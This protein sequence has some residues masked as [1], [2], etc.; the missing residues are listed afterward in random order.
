MVFV[1]LFFILS[2]HLLSMSRRPE[3]SVTKHGGRLKVK[4]THEYYYYYL[5]ASTTAIAGIF[6]LILIPSQTLREGI[7]FLISGII[8]LFWVIPM[9]RRWGKQWYYTG[10]VGT[11]AL[12]ILYETTRVSNPITSD[13][14]PIDTAGIAVQVFQVAFVI[15]TGIIVKTISKRKELS[16]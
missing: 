9:I 13:G 2:S 3:E 4:G 16:G 12:I 8:Q 14:E 5:A 6:H 7:F 1:S 15:I 11:L 10:I